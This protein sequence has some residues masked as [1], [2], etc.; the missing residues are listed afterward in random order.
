MAERILNQFCNDL[1]GKIGNIKSDDHDSPDNIKLSLSVSVS[2]SL[3]LSLSL[4]HTHCAKSFACMRWIESIRP[5]SK[6][7]QE[8]EIA[9][10]KHQY[11]TVDTRRSRTGQSSQMR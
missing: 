6:R 3:S 9:S 11:K 1:D 4:S 5:R 2:V 7:M 10:A 8:E